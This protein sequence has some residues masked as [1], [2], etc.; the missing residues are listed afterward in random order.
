MT[1]DSRIKLGLNDIIPDISFKYNSS[2]KG[3]I[4][5]K[6]QWTTK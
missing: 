2:A 4:K 6:L 1:T 5:E 3:K